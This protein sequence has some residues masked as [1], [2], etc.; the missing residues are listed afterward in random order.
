MYIHSNVNTYV[1]TLY[2]YNGMI[3]G[4]LLNILWVFITS[5]MDE[6][7]SKRNDILTALSALFCAAFSLGWF[8]YYF[9]HTF[10][11]YFY[12]NFS[13]CYFKNENYSTKTK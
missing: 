1:G 6:V 10:W 11:V 9:V 12:S 4:N 8:E 3:I 13:K 7:F 5:F 2:L